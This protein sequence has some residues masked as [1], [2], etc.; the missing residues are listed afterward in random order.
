MLIR[1]ILFKKAAFL[2]AAFFISI[3]SSLAFSKEG[4]ESFDEL[5]KVASQL[6]LKKQKSE[7]I[8]LIV[9]F[10]KNENNKHFLQESDDFLVKVSQTFLS[11]ESQ[12]AYE[13]SINATL[14]NIK[15]SQRLIDICLSLEPENI[16]CLVQKIRLS[17]REKN[18]YFT[19]KYLKILGDFAG[20]TNT[21]NWIDAVI[22]KDTSG[23]GFKD[24]FFLKR[25]SDKADEESFILTVLEI[26]RS[27][28]AKNFSR[29]RSGIE[30]LE[31]TYPDYPDNIF[32]K[33]KLDLDSAEEKPVP[34]ADLGV[35]YTTKCKGLTK[36]MARKFRFD[37]DL[38]QRGSL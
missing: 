36:T 35:L 23:S 16:D 7:A 37:F 2:I 9:K 28:L 10:S 8:Q 32:F 25:F 6:L 14:E 3:L 5:K 27:F 13:S 20:G 4:I 11:K 1:N 33:Q 18:R 12:D 30:F 31:K 26:E 24:K 15:E 29:A 22:Q 21:F 19:E 17:Y 38:C 34:N